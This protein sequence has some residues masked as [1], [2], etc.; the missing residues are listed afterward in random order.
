MREICTSGSER[1]AVRKDRP[2][3]D[4]TP[5]ASEWA[6]CFIEIPLSCL[7]PSQLKHDPLRN[8]RNNLRVCC[9]RTDSALAISTNSSSVESK[10]ALRGGS[11]LV[12]V[13]GCI[14]FR[15]FL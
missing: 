4:S 12:R 11:R 9:S 5:A 14:A 2:Y 10:R 13:D 7:N 1:G 3:R 6:L 15:D 8:C